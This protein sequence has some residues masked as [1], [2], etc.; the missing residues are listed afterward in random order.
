MNEFNKGEQNFIIRG[1]IPSFVNIL[2]FPEHFGNKMTPQMETIHQKYLNPI[3]EIK[4][5][6]KIKTNKKN[7][8]NSKKNF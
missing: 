1:Q 7:N 2:N 8:I 4:N 3:K 5:Y 6:N